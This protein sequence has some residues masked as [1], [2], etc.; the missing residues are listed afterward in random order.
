M[1]S[2]FAEGYNDMYFADDAL[3]NVKA[4]RRVLDQLD[5]KSDV[6]Q[7]MASMD[8]N[9]KV[10][11][12]ME[13]SLD[14]VSKKRFSKAEGRMRGN[15]AR[16]RKLFVPDTAADLGLLLEPLYGKGKEGI[17]NKE[18]FEENFYKKFERGI[19]DFNTSKQRLSREYTA[20]RKNNK[21]VRKDLGKKVP[22]TN[23]THDMAMRVHI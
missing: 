6:Q 11:D 23:F 3:Q 20:L 14:I 17:K 12:I 22:G 5:V 4:V 10:N 13:H 2:K 15:N 18:W 8:V 7:A 1:A 16:R 19:N 21:D 9:I